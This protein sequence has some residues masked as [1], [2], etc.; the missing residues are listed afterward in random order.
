[1]DNKKVFVSG[2]FD[3]LH[4]GHVEFFT[5]AKKLGDYLIVCFASDQMLW[6]Y[7]HKKS[8]LPMEHKRRLL[9]SLTMVDE[10][11]ISEDDEIGLDFKTHFLRLRPQV[12][13]VTGDDKF[14]EAKKYLC[15]Q[16]GAEYVVLPKTLDYERIST[17][18][19][20]KF[21]KTPDSIPLRVDFAAGWLDAPK[22]AR[23]DGYIVNCS[24]SPNVSL[25]EW[26]YK[27]GGGLGGSA[28]YSILTGKDG[29]ASELALGVGWQDPAVVQETGLC[30]W[31]SG[32]RPVLD[33]KINPSFLSGLMAIMWTGKD[34]HTP[35]NADKPR[36]F[37]KVAVVGRLARAAVNPLN[38]SYSG[39]CEAVNL[40]YE[41]HLSEGMETLPE[42]GELAKKYCGGGFGGY[43][44]YLFANKAER[45]KFLQ[46][47]D[48]IAIEPYIREY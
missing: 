14:S 3:I 19:I 39:L 21:I 40:S 24:I 2:C 10:V 30:V 36:D 38:I 12:L 26:S 18:D 45:E 17:T 5:Q 16:V 9:E 13:A 33:F 32:A 6:K 25:S 34:H 41:I 8:S 35:S 28:A 47:S 48:A 1:M 42:A 43:G 15:Q 4:G 27:V 11:V 22:F 29:V 31:K 7:K 23:P 20:I 46:N 37:D 44:L